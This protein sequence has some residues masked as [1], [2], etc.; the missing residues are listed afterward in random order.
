MSDFLIPAMQR[1]S[2][3]VP[4]E[5]PQDKQ[6][7]KLNTNEN[8][9]PPSPRVM[10]ALN[11][12]YISQLNLY[13][14]PTALP[15]RRAIA[16]E[17]GLSTD[18]VFTANGSDE[19]LGFAFCAYCDEA[20]P[21]TIPDIS[22]GFYRVYAKLFG[23]EAKQIALNK[24]FTLPVEKFLNAGSTVAI[25]NPNAPTGIALSVAQIEQIVA[26]N[27]DHIVIIDEAYVDFGAESAISLLS[28]Y[29]N[30]LVI[31]TYSKSYSLA[32]ARLGYA[33]ASPEIIADLD[34]IRN[35]FHPYN[36]NRLTMTAGIEAMQDRDY[37][38]TCCQKVIHQRE[39]SAKELRALGFDLTDSQGN[40][41]FASHPSISGKDYY[42]R[43][44]SKGLL[45]RYWHEPRLLR[46]VRITVGT[47]EQMDALLQKSKEILAEV[48]K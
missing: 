26:S 1:L 10:D 2:P 15:L 35:S 13:S 21:A 47:P 33:F 37:F 19:V 16:E 43:L 38:N 20:S 31:R 17:Y 8:P 18:H 9:Y 6:Y 22:Y 23:A 41:F 4:G 32:G 34:R 44:K 27:A 36:V 14:D 3:Y 24:D 29:P 11:R 42:E 28:Q 40:F 25:A 7:I 46:H 45:V 39:Q 30:L 5:Q 12:E 48:E